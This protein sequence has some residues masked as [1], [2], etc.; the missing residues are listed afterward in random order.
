MAYEYIARIPPSFWK[1]LEQVKEP[2][3]EAALAS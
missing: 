2:E 3:A 1:W